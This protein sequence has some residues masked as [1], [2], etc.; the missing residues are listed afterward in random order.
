[1]VSKLILTGVERSISDKELIVT[2]TDLRGCITYVNKIFIGISGYSE[3]ELLG[4]PHNCIRHP[5]MPRAIFRLLW[6]TIHNGTEFFGYIMN[7]S[8]N[9]DHYWVFAHITPNLDSSR[10][11]IG[12]HSSRRFARKKAIDTMIPIYR[13]LLDEE[14]RYNT[15][16]QGLKSSLVLLHEFVQRSGN[17][18]YN[19]FVLSL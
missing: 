10:A 5:Q 19:R 3:S 9:G 17:D 16:E 4:Q 12:Y 7:L 6:E 13:Q 1:M 2:K 18:S 11:I 15:K 8:K 14:S